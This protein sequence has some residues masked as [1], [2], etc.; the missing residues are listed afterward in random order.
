MNMPEADEYRRTYN[1]I[2]AEVVAEIT[3]KEL[4]D[5]APGMNIPPNADEILQKFSYSGVPLTTADLRKYA[6]RRMR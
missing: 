4:Q 3:R 1:R 6:Q 5:I 2:R